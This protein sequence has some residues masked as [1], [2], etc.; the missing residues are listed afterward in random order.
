MIDS[1]NKTNRAMSNGLVNQ[2]MSERH[3]QKL[4][5]ES[6]SWKATADVAS[7]DWADEVDIPVLDLGP[8]FASGSVKD[9]LALAEALEVICTTVGF[10]YIKGH[11]VPP[12][13]L[14]ETMA[15]ARD[16]F[17]RPEEEKELLS[18]D[19]SPDR[20]GVGYLPLHNKKLPTRSEPNYNE[21]FVIKQ[22]ITLLSALC[23]LLSALCSLPSALCSLFYIFTESPSLLPP[24]LSAIHT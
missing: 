7:L 9:L 15:C 16:Y 24:I 19:G 21:A 11:G 3:A 14:E 5:E 4:R 20:Q 1:P 17:D 6:E 13:L 2:D 22:V 18:M 23:S 10:H 12:A 8:Y